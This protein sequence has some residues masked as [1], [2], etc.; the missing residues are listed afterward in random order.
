MKTS[1]KTI[2]VL[3]LAGAGCM[4]VEAD[5]P[6][7]CKSAALSFP[8]AGPL[9]AA[10]LPSVPVSQDFPLASGVDVS[11]LSRLGFEGGTVSRGDQGGDLSFLSQLSLTVLPGS[12]SSLP[13]LKILDWQRTGSSAV[14][15]I[16]VPATSENLKPYF[17]SGGL[18][19]RVTATGSP[20]PSGWSMLVDL[21]ID[22]K[23]DTTLRL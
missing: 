12:G 10:A 18:Q 6:A 21:C 16:A 2:S 7:V 1:L 23:V 15:S 11:P 13:P 3:L 4:R 9:A 19:I 14:P 20:P 8:G 22:G 17:S 5:L